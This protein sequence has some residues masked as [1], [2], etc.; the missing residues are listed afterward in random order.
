MQRTSSQF[1]RIDQQLQAEHPS[2]SPE[3][4]LALPVPPTYCS[5]MPFAQHNDTA[6]RHLHNLYLLAMK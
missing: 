5:K 1:E 4:V 2:E 3:P 6:R